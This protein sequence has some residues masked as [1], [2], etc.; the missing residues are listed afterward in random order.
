MAVPSTMRRK[1][2]RAAVVAGVVYLGA[3]VLF[4]GAVAAGIVVARLQGRQPP[5]PAAIDIENLRRVDDQ[6]WASAQPEPRHYSE[7]AAAGVELIVDLRTGAAD[8]SGEVDHAELARLGIGYRRL[9]VQDGHVPD[10]ATIARFDDLVDDH[11]GMA[12]VHCG[13]GVGRS[14]TLA[15]GYLTRHGQDLSLWD[16]LALGS[17][18]LEQTWFLTTGDRNEV[19]RRVSEALDV[20][21]RAW[22]RLGSVL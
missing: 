2:R 1:V 22:S 11:E 9:P 21:R 18:T 7:L 20:P 19:V 3:L 16:T 6:V 15:A 14:S 13:A 5:S 8:D 4:H 17:V 12:L 10:A